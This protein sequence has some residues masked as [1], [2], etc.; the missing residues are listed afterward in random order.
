MKKLLAVILIFSTYLVEA[1]EKQ[2]FIVGY[3][4]GDD[5]K[6]FEVCVNGLAYMVV[7]SG[8]SSNLKSLNSRGVGITQIFEGAIRNISTMYPPQPKTCKNKPS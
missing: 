5:V 7:A 3:L 1:K 4:E 2:G 8:K 6:I